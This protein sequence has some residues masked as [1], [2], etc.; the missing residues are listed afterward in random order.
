MSQ[1][2]VNGS[3]VDAVIAITLL[4]ALALLVYRQLTGK[5]VAASQFLLNLLSGLS[6]MVALRLVLAGAWWGAVAGC[7]L[8]AGVLHMAD[9]WRRWER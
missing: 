7:L 9:L 5:G 3:L 1:A 8:L 2:L 6:L 4:E